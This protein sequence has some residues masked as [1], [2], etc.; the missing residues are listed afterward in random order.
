ME[1]LEIMQVLNDAKK[2]PRYKYKGQE[3]IKFLVTG[4]TFEKKNLTIITTVDRHVIPTANF[5]AFTKDWLKAPKG[6]EKGPAPTTAHN[7][8]TGEKVDTPKLEAVKDTT[9][10]GQA[11]KYIHITSPVKVY[12][13]ND[14]KMFRKTLGN[15]M[16]NTSKIS[17]IVHDIKNGLNRLSDYPIVVD[18]DTMEVKDGQ[19]R[20]DAAMQTKQSVYYIFAKPIKLHEIARVNSNTERWKAT[21]FINCYI[22][23][24]SEHYKRL[25]EFQDKYHFPL[26][27]T[28]TIL[29]GNSANGGFSPA[30][31]DAFERGNFTTNDT[32][33]SKAREL[34]AQ[35][36]QF[37]TFEGYKSKYFIQAIEILMLKKL[38]DFSRLL[39][40]YNSNPDRLKVSSSKKEFLNTLELIY[41]LGNQNRVIIC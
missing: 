19:H 41:N 14:Y 22:N 11:A 6:T 40:K 9:L 1:V 5:A 24:G 28:L 39:A 37:K 7:K 34:A 15:R 2:N 31:K 13:T 30:I 8:T 29:T 35:V 26:S 38:C 25:K 12:V 27:L 17:K 21:D 10:S 16:L 18:P 4:Y 32:Y 20:L 3:E 23:Q 33:L 36:E